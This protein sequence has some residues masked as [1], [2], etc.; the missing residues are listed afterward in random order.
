MKSALADLVLH[1]L[2]MPHKKMLGLYGLRAPR[3]PLYGGQPVYRNGR[4]SALLKENVA[5]LPPTK[6]LFWLNLT[7]GSKGGVDTL[8]A[9]EMT[10]ILDLGME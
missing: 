7:Y 5:L 3:C 9:C 2:P 10:A 6:F 8:E 4:N 1:C